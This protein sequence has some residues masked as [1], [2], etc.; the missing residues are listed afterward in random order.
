MTLKHLHLLPTHFL[1]SFAISLM[2]FF[3]SAVLW[4][5]MNNSACLIKGFHSH[6]RIFSSWLFIFFPW[7]SPP[8]VHFNKALN[9]TEQPTNFECIYFHSCCGWIIKAFWHDFNSSPESTRVLTSDKNF[10]VSRLSFD[11][12][13]TL[14]VLLFF[15]MLL[16]TVGDSL[17]AFRPIKV[18]TH[19]T[20]CRPDNVTI[21][22]SIK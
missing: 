17:K 15:N 18:S 19:S 6:Q 22:N 2:K 10:I 7:A 21:Y 1:S 3:W 14:Q 16:R 4:A 12:H 20:Q 8:R 11:L 9:N 5:G 13:T